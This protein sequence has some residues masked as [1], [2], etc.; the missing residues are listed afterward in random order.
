[1]LSI[2]GIDFVAVGLYACSISISEK[3]LSGAPRQWLQTTVPSRRKTSGKCDTTRAEYRL[4][5]HHQP[6]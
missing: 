5:E 3:S 1:M 2:V 6:P 4:D